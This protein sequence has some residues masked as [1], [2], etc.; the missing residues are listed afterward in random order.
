MALLI[1]FFFGTRSLNQLLGH[2]LSFATNSTSTIHR[3]PAYSV[4]D[5]EL[6]METQMKQEDDGN[7][8]DHPMPTADETPSQENTVVK[9]EHD[10]SM[11]DHPVAENLSADHSIPGDSIPDQINVGSTIFVNPRELHEDA[12][13]R[14]GR[15]N[16]NVYHRKPGVEGVHDGQIMVR[17]KKKRFVVVDYGVV[18]ADAD[19]ALAKSNKHMA[20]SPGAGKQKCATMGCEKIGIPVLLYDS[21]PEEPSTLYSRSGLCFTCQRLLNEKRRTKRKKGS[22]VSQASASAVAGHNGAPEVDHHTPMTV[23]SGTEEMYS[24]DS[25]HKKFKLNGEIIELSPDAIVI[26]GPVEGTK[27]QGHDYDFREIGADIQSIVRQASDYTD[28]L[29][30]AAAAATGASAGHTVTCATESN[31]PLATAAAAAAAAASA[32]AAAGGTGEAPNVTGMSDEAV[33]AANAAVAATDSVSGL[34]GTS[35]ASLTH[36]DI[37]A[38]YEKTF[39]TLSKG[40]FLLSQWKISWDTACAGSVAHALSTDAHHGTASNDVV[41]QAVADAVASAAAVAAASR[42]A[43]GEDSNSSNM[44]PLLLAAEAKGNGNGEENDDNKTSEAQK[45]HEDENETG[46]VGV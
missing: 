11:P 9:T 21:S 42:T 24:M 20:I 26:N 3:K 41:D 13:L 32:A 23:S 35:S 22:E 8:P 15:A 12:E 40:I 4:G 43:A 44:I 33:S 6:K 5:I 17:L 1:F 37:L 2:G 14:L 39:L 7:S 46:M 10:D 27:Y 19:I 18:P 31:D 16:G 38:V 30:A 25:A 29:V 36:D 28:R 34:L 45:G